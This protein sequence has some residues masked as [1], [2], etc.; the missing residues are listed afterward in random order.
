MGVKG[1]WDEVSKTYPG[2]EVSLAQLNTEHVEKTGRP[3]RI[4]VDAPIDVYKYKTATKHV[5]EG[6]YGG[7]NH[8]SRT[9]FYHVLH[10]LAA[11]VQPVFVYDGPGKPK[12]KRGVNT[13]AS[14]YRPYTP[15]A[16]SSMRSKDEQKR[17]RDPRHI[18]Y[19]S[20]KFLCYLG[21]PT[22]D[23]P[24]EAEGECAA[25]EKAG[26]VDAVMST[27]GDAFLFGAQTVLWSLN[28][29]K[30]ECMVRVFKV[31]DL[32][33]GNS[34]ELQRVIFTMA[35]LAGGDYN[36]GL[37]NCG[38]ELALEIG[39]S[40][41][42]GQLW[43][44]AS[45]ENLWYKFSGWKNNLAT[46][47]EKGK[48]RRKHLALARSLKS[49]DSFPDRE[50][51]K[52]YM[53]E[54]KR[55]TT[56]QTIDWIKALDVLSLREFTR[57]Y[58]DWKN[59]HYAVK[60]V[61][62][63]V[64]SLL[65]R[66]LLRCLASEGADGSE[67]ITAIMRTR[68]EG[69]TRQISVKP[70]HD[71]VVPVGV[72]AEPI[73]DYGHHLKKTEVVATAEW[74]PHWLVEAACPTLILQLQ[75]EISRKT[76][77]KST[78]G[79]PSESPA[80]KRGRGRPRKDRTCVSLSTATPERG[81]SRLSKSKQHAV[82]TDPSSKPPELSAGRTALAPLNPN[83]SATKMV[84]KTPI[85]ASALTAP[86]SSGAKSTSATSLGSAGFYPSEII[87]LTNED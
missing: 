80:P 47:L 64:I 66:R 82:G 32:K 62:V 56:T 83:R 13:D 16:A 42:C 12:V 67:W 20:K 50:V 84:S 70:D 87:D 41:Y 74:L 4:A 54:T 49:N 71:R 79:S 60:F 8:P 2:K 69:A 73:V 28:A 26:L 46:D 17:E 21:V 22:L 86:K 29:V 75:E 35:I 65:V 33:K 44:I 53:G 27:D 85:P 9:L 59:R 11:G 52:Y 25:L 5:G 15:S 58:F 6:N 23:A 76:K 78:G 14:T 43:A 51:V 38:A 45:H 48:F 19:L 30:K 55:Q 77:R 3:M 72:L 61:R 37:E 34:A 7:M 57:K 63:T 36:S 31:E 68:G 1:F 18:A 24:G 40:K 39:L 81:P 10:L